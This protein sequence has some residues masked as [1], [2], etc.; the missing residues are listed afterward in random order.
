M[1]EDV[2]TRD[3]HSVNAT[4]GSEYTYDEILTGVKAGDP[5]MKAIRKAAKPKTFLLQ[6]GGGAWLLSF[7]T[8]CTQKEAQRFI[9]AYFERYPE[10]EVWFEDLQFE[11][12]SKAKWDGVTRTASGQ[13]ARTY[14]WRSPVGSL[15]TFSEEDPHPRAKDQS[16]YFKPTKV[17][18][19]PVQGMS[20]HLMRIA[21]PMAIRLLLRNPQWRDKCL[22]VNTIYDSM[23]FDCHRSVLAEVVPQLRWVM[24]FGV[25]EYLLNAVDV[26]F[27]IPLDVDVSMGETWADLKE[28]NNQYEH[29]R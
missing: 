28:V 10:V 7:K 9:D 12:E 8:G 4:F 19:Y 23:I 11:V 17:K 2:K 22:F 27:N 20:A 1:I 5:L 16:P 25:I 24:E 26:D 15:H 18:N 29:I 13:E 21:L 3:V 6:Y 14:T